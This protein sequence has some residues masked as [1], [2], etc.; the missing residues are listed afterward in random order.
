[1]P[2]L[3]NIRHEL[4]ALRVAEGRSWSE[5]CRL[6]GFSDSS[7]GKQGSRLSQNEVIRVRVA[8]LIA[9]AT[10]DVIIS[11]KERA[12][13]LSRMAQTKI[14]DIYDVSDKGIVLKTGEI[15]SELAEAV[16]EIKFEEWTGGKDKR[17]RGSRLTVKLYDRIDAIKTLNAMSNEGEAAE[18]L[19]ALL[20]RIRGYQ[21]QNQIPEKADKYLPMDGYDPANIIIDAEP[22]SADKGTDDV[23][24]TE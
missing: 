4:V 12:L 1:M 3:D 17:A 13:I 22:D 11:V 7:A 15:P 2:V 14:T 9:S 6:A 16:S 21:K 8:E 23:L 18:G 20:E 10:S 19:Y 24:N 5:G